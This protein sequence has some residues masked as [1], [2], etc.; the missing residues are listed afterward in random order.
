VNELKQFNLT[1]LASPYR[2]YPHG[3]PL[4]ARH[5]AKIAGRLMIQ[6]IGV[7]SPIAHS[8]MLAIYGGI[9]PTANEIWVEFDKRFMLMCDALV[10]AKMD[11]WEQSDGIKEEIEFFKE[12]GKPIFYLDPRTLALSNAA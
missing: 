12:V 1:Y 3:L 8:H 5:V 6:G 2:K 4:A 11:G 9:L 10:V 7:F